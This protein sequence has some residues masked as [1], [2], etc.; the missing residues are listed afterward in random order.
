MQYYFKIIH[1]KFSIISNKIQEV[2]G[3]L[4]NPPK[5]K[6]VL[7]LWYM[8][9]ISLIGLLLDKENV[10]NTLSYTFIGFIE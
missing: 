9:N 3:I 5:H 7:A 6:R 4:A 1:K 2:T 8:I 10:N